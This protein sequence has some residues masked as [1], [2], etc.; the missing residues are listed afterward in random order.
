LDVVRRNTYHGVYH[1]VLGLYI[2]DEIRPQ[3]GLRTSSLDSSTARDLQQR[4]KVQR[5]AARFVER[6]QAH[7]TSLETCFIVMVEMGKN[8]HC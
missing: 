2:V 7:H 4:H 3:L 8:A 6:L 1:N 5:R